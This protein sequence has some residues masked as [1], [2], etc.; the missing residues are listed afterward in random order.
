MRNYKFREP[1]VGRKNYIDTIKDNFSSLFQHHWDGSNTFPYSNQPWH[2]L[3]GNMIYHQGFLSISNGD[4]WKILHEDFTKKLNNGDTIDSGG[5]FLIDEGTYYLGSI[6]DEDL[7]LIAYPSA[8]ILLTQNISLGPATCLSCDIRIYATEENYLYNLSYPATDT[9]STL[10]FAQINPS[11]A[12]SFVGYYDAPLPASKFSIT[13]RFFTGRSYERE[14]AATE[15]REVNYYMYLDTNVYLT[16]TDPRFYFENIRL[17]SE[18]SNTKTLQIASSSVIFKN[19]E[20]SLIQFDIT[21]FGTYVFEN[22]KFNEVVFNVELYATRYP[23][24][25]IFKNCSFHITIWGVN[26][27][28]MDKALLSFEN[29]SGQNLE[30]TIVKNAN[31]GTYCSVSGKIINDS[32]GYQLYGDVISSSIANEITG[33]TNIAVG[34]AA[35]S[36]NVDLAVGC[37]TLA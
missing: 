26:Y 3:P 24:R 28:I 2:Q 36:F 32:Y 13:E 22:C 10:H 31:T 4:E 6:Q 17:R 23:S 20:F 16:S 25:I 9:A 18:D 35:T 33:T 8:N 7:N 14:S 37:I 30:A 1:R 27:S 5:L 21:D 11:I 12:I 29:P 34:S 15:I 19:C